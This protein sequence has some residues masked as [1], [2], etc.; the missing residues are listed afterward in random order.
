MAETENCFP[1]EGLFV[2]MAVIFC[3]NRSYVNKGQM[4]K[5]EDEW[6]VWKIDGCFQPETENAFGFAGDYD[7][8]RRY[9]GNSGGFGNGACYRGDFESG[10]PSEI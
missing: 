6:D 9:R 3:Y 7:L 8:C 4:L 10:F 5:A 2:E 1:W